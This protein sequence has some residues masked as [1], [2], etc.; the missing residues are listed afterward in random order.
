MLRGDL[1]EAHALGIDLIERTPSDDP[2]RAI[3]AE[4]LESIDMLRGLEPA[5]ATLGDELR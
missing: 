2:S 5:N 1:E 4:M 3:R